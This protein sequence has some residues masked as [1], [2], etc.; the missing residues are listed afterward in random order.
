MPELND[1]MMKMWLAT[2]KWQW[3]ERMKC[4]LLQPAGSLLECLVGQRASQRLGSASLS[5]GARCH[6]C[7]EFVILLWSI[8]EP[9]TQS[10]S[11]LD[12]SNLQF[13]LASSESSQISYWSVLR[14]S[15]QTVQM[16]KLLPAQLWKLATGYVLLLSVGSAGS[17]HVTPRN[18]MM[19]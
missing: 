14:Y 1:G 19:T 8:L 6:G 12:L 17:F 10:N 13:Q 3:S 18:G 2:L 9:E 11:V 15:V 7:R 5:N 16:S 4:W